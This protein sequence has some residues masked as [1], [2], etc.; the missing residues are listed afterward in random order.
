[1]IRKESME[2]SMLSMGIDHDDIVSAGGVGIQ[3]NPEIYLRFVFIPVDNI[4]FH[5][6]MPKPNPRY[7][8]TEESQRIY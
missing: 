8:P 7:I 2:P 5:N 3:D 4:Y 1:M 6:T